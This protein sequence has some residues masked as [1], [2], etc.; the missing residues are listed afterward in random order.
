LGALGRRSRRISEEGSQIGWIVFTVQKIIVSSTALG[1]GTTS[2][3]AD[4]D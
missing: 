3:M 1:P 2:I 4:G